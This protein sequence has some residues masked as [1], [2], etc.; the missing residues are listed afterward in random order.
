LEAKRVTH[1]TRTRTIHQQIDQA[2]AEANAIE[3]DDV[4][5]ATLIEKA[6][7]VEHEGRNRIALE[8][9]LAAE[10]EARRDRKRQRLEELEREVEASIADEQ[11][12]A[13]RRKPKSKPRPRPPPTRPQADSGTPHAGCA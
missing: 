5:K 12:Q 3:G 7:L 13:Q 4:R 9:R 1:A 6:E 11:A 2:R 10:A 8:V